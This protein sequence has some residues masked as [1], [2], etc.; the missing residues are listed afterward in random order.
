MKNN[1][2]DNTSF[3]DW[4]VGFSEGDGSFILDKN[5]RKR[6]EIWQ[7]IKDVSVLEF[8][9]QNLEFGDIRKPLY[10]PDIAIFYVH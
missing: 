8:V 4:F 1:F 2:Y 6:F 9:Q 10:R 5:N 3:L 7:H